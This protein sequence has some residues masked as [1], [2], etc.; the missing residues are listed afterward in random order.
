MKFTSQLRVRRNLSAVLYR[1]SNVIALNFICHWPNK[2][3]AL[4]KDF[5]VTYASSCQ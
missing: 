2:Q 3:K 5:R 1:T 4:P